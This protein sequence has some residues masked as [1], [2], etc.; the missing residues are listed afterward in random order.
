MK[1]ILI[2]IAV[3]VVF[4][5]AS[6]ETDI[7]PGQNAV[8]K[9][10]N[11]W[12]GQIYVPDGSGGL[13]D[14]GLGYQHLLTSSTASGTADSMF[15][16][17]FDGLLELKAKVA[18]N[19][20]DLT[21]TTNGETVVERYTD[22]TVIIG[23]GRIFIDGGKSTTGVKVDSIYFEAEFDWDPGQIYVVAGHGRTG[24]LEDEH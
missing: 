7:D 8:V 12:W 2:L 14:I 4:V 19:V 3:G 11:E 16:D 5:L 22:G 20:N 6:C 18:C 21:F 13:E 9:M 15:I 24:F 23:N 17:D 10:S 1:Q